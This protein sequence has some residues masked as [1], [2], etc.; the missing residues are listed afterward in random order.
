MI[1][2][3]NRKLYKKIVGKYLFNDQDIEDSVQD[4]F[5]RVFRYNPEMIENPAYVTTALINTAMNTLSS[6]RTLKRHNTNI[7]LFEIELNEEKEFPSLDEL[8]RYEA[9]EELKL[10]AKWS[11]K[12]QNLTVKESEAF[13][14]FLMVHDSNLPHGAKKTALFS[15]FKK[16]RE[17]FV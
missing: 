13:I 11:K 15:A 10:I 9:R 3:K 12:K 7:S 1:Y 5:L 2:Q 17:K 14:Q 8:P 16:I 6:R 4:A